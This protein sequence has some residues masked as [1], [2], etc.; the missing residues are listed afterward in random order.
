VCANESSFAKTIRLFINPDHDACHQQT[1]VLL[2]HIILFRY[3]IRIMTLLFSFMTL[4]YHLF[5]ANVQTIIFH[6]FIISKRTIISL[7]TLLLFHLFFQHKLFLL[8]QLSHCYLHFFYIKLFLQLSFSKTIITLISVRIYYFYYC[9]YLTIICIIFIA[10]YYCY[11][12]LRR[13]LLHLFLYV[14]IISNIAIILLL[15]A[16]FYIKLLLL[17]YFSKPII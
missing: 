11:Y 17:L 16:L 15:F 2:Y 10:N 3:I 12:L 1:G 9:Y 6:Y 14:Y 13:P 4:L 5:F 7:M 8:L